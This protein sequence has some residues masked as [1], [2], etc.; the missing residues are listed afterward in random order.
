MS[1]RLVDEL[2]PTVREGKPRESGVTIASDHFGQIDNDLLEQTAEYLDFIEIGVSIPLMVERSKL[3]ER[4]RRYHDLGV[5]VLSGGTLIQVA[6]H[7][8]ITPQVLER[9][10]ALGFDMVGISESAGN[11]PIETKRAILN[12]ISKLSMDYI[13]GVGRKDSEPTITPG[14]MISRIQEAFE[15][16][17]HK[18][19]IETGEEGKGGGLYDAQ[20]EISW[21]TLN[22]TAG[23]FGPP[24]LIFAAPRISQ[25]TA[26]ILEFGPAVNL[27]GVPMD[28]A[29][30]LEMQRLGLTAET[31]GLSRPI[32]SIEGSPAAKFVYYLIRAEHPLDQ[33]TLIQR[34]GLPKRTLQA[35][36]SCLVENGFVREVSEA[37]D[38]R[39]HKYTLG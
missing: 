12:N 23:R 33:S 7:K 16:K 37:S 30:T 24:N 31:L 3:L 9:L 8:G 4:V 28:E 20:G 34:S 17:S 26:L 14:Y 11:M 25:R 19:I 2:I 5:K 10:R 15:L 6:V 36:L 18:V 22:E 39:R 13:F 1:G 27:A 38:M 35:A 32:Q 29:L 21:D